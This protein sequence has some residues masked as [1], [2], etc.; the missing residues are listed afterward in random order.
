MSA[1]DPPPLPSGFL[2][3][4]ATI[5]GPAGIVREPQSIEP[6]VTDFWRQYRGR[7]AAVLRP[8]STAEV[9]AVVAEAA[10]ARVPLVPQS[11]NTGLV[12]GGIPD[13][14][15]RQVVL[16]LE[17]MTRI[18]E[19]DP[20]GE[21]IVVEAGCVLETVQQKAAEIGRLFPL[22]LGA[23]GSCRIGGNLAT[24]A[25]GVAVL[26]YGMMR[27][28]VLGLEVV[29]ADGR[30]WDGLKTLR[31]DNT[32]YDLKQLFIGSE[33]TLG[34]ITAAA[35]ELFPAPKDRQTL[36]LGIE[37][38]RIA[39]DVFEL[40]REK[41][42]EVIS[43]FELLT[44]FGVEAA[45]AH[46]PGVRRPLPEPHPWHLL[47]ELS[48]SFEDG[49]SEKLEAV[50]ERAVEMGLVRDGTRADSEA[51][52]ANMW[53]IR[54]GQSEATRHM[55]FIVRSDVTVPIGRIPEL[56]ERM[57]T[58]VATRAPGVTLVPFGHV[59]DGNLHFNFIAPPERVDEL[60]PLLLERLYDEV[61]TLGGSISAEHGIGRMKREALWRRRPALDRELMARI[62]AA[63]D[64]DGILNP[65]V[66]LDGAEE[67]S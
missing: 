40:F 13:A 65:G 30:V 15:G 42:G 67:R 63:F 50:M 4:C 20:R 9:A 57:A 45:C 21:H 55:G 22:A 25:G 51:Q 7:A 60:A 61:T 36:W 64:P 58:W 8:A 56:V 12:R 14:S 66:I 32:G 16:S 48:W 34:V 29:L 3:R 49:L 38:P 1:F 35:L 6:Y 28:L 37:G 33:G 52:R 39:L 11:G 23:Q 46:L 19:V 31:K 47:I 18:R 27:D 10:R 43:S 59:G 26:R 62:K 54:E 44:G 41:A 5:L 24:N 17:R 2:E 53:R